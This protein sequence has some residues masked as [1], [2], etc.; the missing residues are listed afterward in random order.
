MRWSFRFA[1][2]LGID[3]RI[4]VTFLLIV[5]WGAMM[6][7][8]HAQRAGLN[9]MI[10]AAFGALM[11]L[12]LFACVTLHEL[13]HAVVA[14]H[15]GIS[16]R[17]IVLLPIGGVAFLG[18]IPE[19][20]KQELFIAAAGP[21][22]NVAILL[23]LTPLL[24]FTYGLD[25]LLPASYALSP[26]GSVAGIPAGAL[27]LSL[28]IGSNFMLIAFNLIPAFPLDGGRMLRAI[29]GFFM[30]WVRATRIASK[31]GQVLAVALAFWALF[32]GDGPNIMLAIIAFF[33]FMG[34]GAES[35]AAQA[36]TVLATRRV[37]NAYN[38]NAITLNLEHR[39]SHVIE[40]ILT[41]YQPDYAVVNWGKL[42][43]VVTR[44]DVLKWLEEDGGFY[45][46]YVTEIMRDAGRVLR[47]QSHQTLDEVVR[48]MQDSEQR[49][50]AVYDGEMFL[51]LV[52]A[53]DIAEA[54]TVLLHL[55]KRFERMPPDV[56]PWP[57]P[58]RG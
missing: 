10:G 9:P 21:L 2:V 24:A 3:L 49:V 29:L 32:G 34:A 33:I 17:D 13:G 7:S 52:S 45:D 5:V 39:V 22:V 11:V 42:Q 50:A 4:H 26:Q 30:P 28:L 35:A 15:Y 23:V 58:T 25:M 54:Q 12:L 41:S 47:V 57:M 27:V 44:A 38:M 20:P 56:R 43:G 37:G 31:V 14:M 46:V 55:A 8:N 51:G 48:Q 53:E 6:G 40:D 18:R 19:N 16:V 1:R 36:G